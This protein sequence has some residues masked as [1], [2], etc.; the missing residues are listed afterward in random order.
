MSEP[1]SEIEAQSLLREHKRIARALEI[2][3]SPATPKWASYVVILATA[4]ASAAFGSQLS[5]QHMN[6]TLGALVGGIVGLAVDGWAVSR[7]LEAA[8][9]LL[10]VNRMD[11][12][13]P[14][15]R[16]TSPALQSEG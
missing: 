8:L 5:G 1:V 14:A 15:L 2:V 13:P 4:A 6:I 10:K 12:A 11:N 7:R 16:H 3:S 9:V